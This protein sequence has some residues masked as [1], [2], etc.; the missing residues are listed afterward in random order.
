MARFSGGSVGGSGDAGPAG[1]AGSNGTNG[2]NGSDGKDS[3]FLGTWNS[4]TAF[5]AAYQ[6]GPVGLADGDWWAFVK[7][8]TNPNKI[9]VVREDPNSATGWVIDDNEHFILP[10]G[11]D[12]AD[13]TNGTNGADGAPG[14]D[15]SQGPQGD[16]GPMPFN[17]QGDFNYGVTYAGNDAVTFQGGLWKLNNFIGAAGY[18]PTPGQWTLIIPAGTAGADGA[19]GADGAPGNDGA[20]G[21][22]GDP[23]SPGLVYL[24]N[25]VSGNGYIANLAVVKGSDNNLYIA[26][27]SGGL[28]DPVGNTAEWSIFLPSGSGGS[29]NIADFVFTDDSDNTGRSIISLPG[30]KGMTIA[31]GED[32]DLYLTAGDDLY[33]QTLGAGDDIHL[34][35]ADDIRFTTNNEDSLTETVPQWT[36]NSEGIFH[37]PGAGYIENT[38]SN[39]G[40]GS[41]NDTLKL[42]PDEDL[43]WNGGDQ[44][45]II[46]PTGSNHIHIRAGG[47][48]D[49]SNA[50]LILGGER[51]KVQVSDA[52]RLVLVSTRPPGEEVSENQ[53]VFGSDGLLTG[54]A[55]DSLIKVNGLYG[56]DTDP[57]FLLAPDTVVISGDNG[58]F[59]NDPTVADNQIATIG[60]VAASRFGASASYY[61]T[62]DQGPQT[63]ADTVQ[64][65]TYNNNDWQTGVLLQNS[66]QIKMLSAGKYNIAFSAQ[67]FQISN[68]GTVNIWLSKNGS[69]MTNTNTKIVV[70]SNAPYK[71][72][73]WNFFVDA[74]ADDYYELIWSSSSTNTK[75]EYDAAQTI[76]GNV[77]PEI[78]S[79]IVT[80]NQVG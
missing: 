25:Y 53:W 23:G 41:G 9:Y 70:E 74:A 27:S 58:E 17:Y 77:H 79:I 7:D 22:Q 64:A 52:E 35:A 21:P 65:F 6:G 32:S 4:V 56:K 8:N 72:A 80:V 40:D 66:S 29:A 38:L 37:L 78:P 10:A 5:L 69:P 36:M 15:G 73:A 62:V 43:T 1:P 33:I 46:D 20:Q 24:G 63:S 30:D 61:S 11:A 47:T 51:T 44:Y 2:A 31:A 12:G 68:T 49:A 3:L 14:A 75:I 42:V 71:V 28:G 59:L 57:L 19:D 26:T 76:N 13:G 55:P 60:D 39:S 67:L 54:P 50:E 16:P 34:N 45:I 18:A 48:Q